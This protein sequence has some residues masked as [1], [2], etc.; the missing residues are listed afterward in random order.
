MIHMALELVPLNKLTPNK[1]V[2]IMDTKKMALIIEGLMSS[3]ST[4]EEALVQVTATTRVTVS[5]EERVTIIEGSKS[6]QELH[7]LRKRAAAKKSKSKS[8]GN[9]D[10]YERADKEYKAAASAIATIQDIIDDSDDPVATLVRFDAAASSV[11]QRYLLV[12]TENTEVAFRLFKDEFE[13]SNVKARKEAMDMEV[14]VPN[15]IRE[16]LLR[17]DIVDAFYDRLSRHDATILSLLKKVAY[18]REVRK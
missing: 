12:K 13:L 4:L 14:T 17:Y 9:I 6:L 16:E 1:E 18:M 5:L 11:L 15:D 7:L 8:R 2:S 3:G 10:S